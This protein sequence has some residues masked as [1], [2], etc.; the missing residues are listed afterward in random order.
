MEPKDKK[1]KKEVPPTLAKD[2]LESSGLK[3]QLNLL[4]RSWKGQYFRYDD[5][6]YVHVDNDDVS[7]WVTKYLISINERSG[8]R[9]RNDVLADIKGLTHLSSTV[10]DNTW[11][12]GRFCNKEL[13]AT[14]NGIL[15]ITAIL[16]GNA[17]CLI[18]N[19]PMFF[20]LSTL[21]Y[22]YDPIADCPKFKTTLLEIQPDEDTRLFIQMWFGYNLVKDVTQHKFAIFEGTGGNG[23]SVVLSALREL[24]GIK[25]TSSVAL[26]QFDLERTFPLA[27]MVGK[28]A[29]IVE[30]ISDVDKV[31]EGVLKAVVGGSVISIERKHG[32]QFDFMPTAKLTFA[33]NTLPR[34]KDRTDGVWRRL[35]LVPFRQ[36]FT[37]DNRDTKLVEP[38]FWRNSGELPGILNWAIEGLKLL[39]TKGAFVE[40][41]ASKAAKIA[42]KLE[43]NPADSFLSENCEFGKKASDECFAGELYRAYRDYCVGGGFSPLNSR[44]FAA[45]VKRVFPLAKQ[46]KNP[47]YCGNK[48]DRLWEGVYLSF[49]KKEIASDTHDTIETPLVKISKFPNIYTDK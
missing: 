40:P 48:R 11:I 33:G 10:N 43:C 21:P 15:D 27:A 46:S 7:S 14:K 9:A 13:L 39:R 29:N 44:N 23:K 18:S 49:Y 35:I 41:E 16:N 37:D 45:E 1:Q 30:E 20:S 12:D 24:L 22:E 2:F 19:S 6:Q 32:E 31:A 17:N 26:E 28:L 47:T 34:F 5:G 36:K 8:T 42:Y 38:D 4:F 3:R 25:N